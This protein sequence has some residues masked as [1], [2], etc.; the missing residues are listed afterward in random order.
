MRIES[1]LAV[2]RAT[3]AGIRKSIANAM[4]H[5]SPSRFRNDSDVEKFCS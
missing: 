2:H 1:A 4:P 3:E 5:V